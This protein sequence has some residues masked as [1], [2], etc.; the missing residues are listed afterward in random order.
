MTVR[1]FHGAQT[2]EFFA[3]IEGFRPV[4]EYR[5]ANGLMTIAHTGVPPASNAMVPP[6]CISYVVVF[7]EPLERA[8]QCLQYQAGGPSCLAFLIDCTVES[9]EVLRSICQ[10][11]RSRAAIIRLAFP[12]PR[13]LQ[14]GGAESSRRSQK[15]STATAA[16]AIR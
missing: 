9:K 10:P 8:R 3:S 2:Q 16:I 14:H 4:L 15:T 6:C 5:L 11:I 12:N 1:I 13:I 7:S